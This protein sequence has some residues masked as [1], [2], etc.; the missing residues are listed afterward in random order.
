MLTFL[1][2]DRN[3]TRSGARWIGCIYRQ[4]V[5]CCGVAKKRH[6]TNIEAGAARDV[7]ASI[8]VFE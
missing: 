8:C 4:D 2:E 1:F 7:G 5:A 6:F 3:C